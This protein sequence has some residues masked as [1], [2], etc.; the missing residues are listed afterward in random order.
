M[1][2]RRDPLLVAAVQLTSTDQ[3]EQ[4]LEKAVV[5]STRAAEA[6]ARLITLPENF[7]F[8]GGDA[9]KLPHAQAVDGRFS[10]ELGRVAQ[11]HNAW[12]LLGSIPEVGPDPAHTY[13]TAVLLS[14]AGAPVAR[15][16]K[17]HLFDVDLPGE[18][19]LRESDSVA[20]GDEV[21]VADV[22]GWRLGLSICYDLR[23]P[24]LY[25]ELAQHGA[26]IL[27]VPAAFTLQTGK[28][29]WDVLLRARAIENQ[30]FVVAPAQFGHHGGKRWS[31][32]KAQI[33]DP[34][35]TV[36]AC[37]PEREGFVLAALHKEELDRPRRMLPAL[38]H[39]RIGP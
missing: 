32:G 24:E 30:A 33:I 37:A 7:G 29:H 5:W 26:E 34:W 9:D 17:I 3:V 28:D 38:R 16:R 20:S 23:F 39:R 11:K 22:D 19:S 27:A 36:L 12:I 2:A 6:G 31:W 35:G 14:P 1:P 21:V 10:A 13:N 25:R 18:L 15:Y 4:N 8:L